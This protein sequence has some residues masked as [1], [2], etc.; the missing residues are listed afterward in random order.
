MSR[1]LTLQELTKEL[2]VTVPTIY[3]WRKKGLPVIKKAIKNSL[4]KQVRYDIDA[5]KLWLIQRA[6]ED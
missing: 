6:K 2:N 4:K 5:V 3:N 1:L